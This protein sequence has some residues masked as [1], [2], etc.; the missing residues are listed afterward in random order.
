MGWENNFRNIG[1]CEYAGKHTFMLVIQQ[2]KTNSKRSSNKYP[3]YY[4]SPQDSGREDAMQNLNTMVSE[5][6]LCIS[7]KLCICGLFRGFAYV[8]LV[9][10]YL[11]RLILQE[12]CTK[13]TRLNKKL[14]NFSVNILKIE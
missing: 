12:F 4:F 5:S 8:I 3:L 11:L 1:L 6:V 14:C 10:K 2:A 7:N 13:R 9:I